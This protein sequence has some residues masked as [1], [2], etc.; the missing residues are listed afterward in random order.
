MGY[1]L[2][3][4]QKTA[5]KLLQKVVEDYD[6][7]AKDFSGTRKVEWQS[8]PL[9]LPHIKDNDYIVDIGCGNGRVLNF[10]EKH[11]QIKYLGIDNSKNLL[12]LAKENHAKSQFIHG[13]MLNLPVESKTA[14]KALAIA[15]LH[16]I[17]SRELR[18]KAVQEAHRILK[19]K[20]LYILTVWN[21][22]QPK[23]KK[24]IWRA[25]MKWLLSFGK[26]DSR[27]TFIPWGNS[28]VNRY[29][30]AFTLEEVKKL[31][32]DNGFKILEDYV[33][34]NFVLICQKI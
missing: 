27:D 21:L 2:A 20:G 32:I 3:M 11:R 8:F 12:E 16:H 18:A 22:F 28:G 15:S 25:R 7:I 9:I 4:R 14:D 10:L 19:E 33:S 26:Y 34:D 1:N 31:L 13:D 6:N 29:Y 30:Y 23:Y 17:P 5:K 24:Y